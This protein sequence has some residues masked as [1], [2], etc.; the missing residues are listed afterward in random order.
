MIFVKIPPSCGIFELTGVSCD[1]AMS[2]WSSFS[3]LLKARFF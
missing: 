2:N 1:P 3:A